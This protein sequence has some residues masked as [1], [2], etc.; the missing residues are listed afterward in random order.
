MYVYCL[1]GIFC[2]PGCTSIYTNHVLG[3]GGG[4]GLGYTVLGA[5]GNGVTVLGDVA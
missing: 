5:G 2:C 1:G 4:S 3:L